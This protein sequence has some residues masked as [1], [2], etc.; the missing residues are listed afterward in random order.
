MRIKVSDEQ[1]RALAAECLSMAQLIKRLGLV[2]AGGNYKTIKGRIAALTIDISHFTGQ[3]WNRGERYRDVGRQFSW[4]NILVK[5][6]RYTSSHR[7]KNRLLSEG[8]KE[9]K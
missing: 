8:L 4:D 7:L 9:R 5:N 2:P 1:F 6:S 3:G